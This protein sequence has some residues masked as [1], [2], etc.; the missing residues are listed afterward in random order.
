MTAKMKRRDFI[1][2]IGGAAAAWPFAARAQQAGRV[3]RVGVLV[4]LSAD[5]PETQARVGAFL[6]GLQELGWAIGRNVRIDS[7]FP[8]NAGSIAGSAAEVLALAPEVVLA[9]ATPSVQALLR[10][11]RPLPIV[12]VAV[13]EP[14]G[15]RLVGSM[16]RPGGNALRVCSGGFGPRPEF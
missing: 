9:N 15:S 7:R 4:N 6:R 5:S 11:S 3:R 12:F 16:G 14:V 10:L 2:L 13:T 8:S 1:T